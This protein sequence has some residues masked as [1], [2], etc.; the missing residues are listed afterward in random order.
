M[1]LNVKSL[2]FCSQMGAKTMLKESHGKIINVSS[3]VG[4]VVDI[5]I[6]AYTARKAAVINLTRSLAL[7]WAR[8]SIK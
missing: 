6:S 2:F 7:E 3:V 4:A 5:G 8:I 1:D